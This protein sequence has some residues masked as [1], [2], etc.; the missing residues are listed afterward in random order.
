MTWVR[1]STSTSIV[2]GCVTRV[3]RRVPLVGFVYPF[4][5]MLIIILSIFSTRHVYQTKW[6][7]K[8]L[9]VIHG[10]HRWHSVVWH[11][12]VLSS[13]MTYQ[14]VCSYIHTTGATSG[15][16]TAYSSGAPEFTPVFSRFVLLDLKF[17]RSLFVLLYFF[18]AANVKRRTSMDRNP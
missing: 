3:T 12:S 6:G 17:Y 5:E 4:D 18:I 16:G 13:F 15:A 14:Q 9:E 7:L 8:Y 10:H 2:T 1:V 11:F